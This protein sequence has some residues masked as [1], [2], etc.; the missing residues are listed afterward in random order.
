[1]E[2]PPKKESSDQRSDHCGYR[3]TCNQ[4]EEHLHVFTPYAAPLRVRLKPQGK[5]WDRSGD[6]GQQR[7]RGPLWA[8]CAALHQVTPEPPRALSEHNPRGPMK[9]AITETGRDRGT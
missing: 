7:P 8:L 2:K 1:M 5:P 3:T 6:L 9:K 4:V